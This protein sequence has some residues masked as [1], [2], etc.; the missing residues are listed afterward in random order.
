MPGARGSTAGASTT[1]GSDGSFE[2]D[3]VAAGPVELT[4]A[5][6]GYDTKTL[7]ADLRRQPRP[8]H[9]IALTGA[10]AAGD[11]VV[12]GNRL[13]ERRASQTKKS[14]RQHGRGALRQ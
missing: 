8:G 9:P 3:N 7:T 1:T 10:I 11:I 6:I 4:I 5:Y 12:T 2:L 13:A 14:R